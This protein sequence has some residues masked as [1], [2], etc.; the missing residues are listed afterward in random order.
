[1]LLA[2]CCLHYILPF[3]LEL[4]HKKKKPI[5]A[6]GLFL[7]GYVSFPVSAAGCEYPLTDETGNISN[8]FIHDPR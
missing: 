4:M 6:K 3:S 7:L 2:K 5:S 1:M 8:K